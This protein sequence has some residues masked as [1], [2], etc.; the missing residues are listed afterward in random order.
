MILHNVTAAC[1]AQIEYCETNKK[2]LYAPRNG[3]CGH[4]GK[5]IY[6]PVCGKYDR[7][8]GISVEQAATSH[9]TGC[10]HCHKS[11]VD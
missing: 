5:N 2:T 11:F 1:E 9:I 4:C 6:I 7:I 10:P 3:I 8:T